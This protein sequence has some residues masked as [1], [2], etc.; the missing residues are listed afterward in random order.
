[1]RWAQVLGIPEAVRC[2]PRV[3]RGADGFGWALWKTTRFMMF[4]LMSEV[5]SHGAMKMLLLASPCTVSRF[6][7]QEQ[8]ATLAEALCN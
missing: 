8:I 7:Y 4:R 5:P 3:G 6:C 1:M 2:F